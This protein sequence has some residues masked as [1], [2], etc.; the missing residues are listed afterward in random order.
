[1]SLDIWKKIIQKDY[2]EKIKEDVEY[3]TFRDIKP[4]C[5]ITGFNAGQLKDL[6]C[7]FFQEYTRDRDGVAYSSSKLKD[8]IEEGINHR[9]RVIISNRF[10]ALKFP[11]EE[12]EGY[13]AIFQEIAVGLQVNKLRNACPNFVY[14]FGLCKTDPPNSIRKNY[15]KQSY[16]CAVVEHINGEN[17]SKMVGKKSFEDHYDIY[18]QVWLSLA[19]AQSQIGLT[20]YDLHT[21]NIIVITLSETIKIDYPWGSIHTDKLVKI[22]DW[23]RSFSYGEY[24]N[25]RYT[26]GKLYPR[27]GIQIGPNYFYDCYLILKRSINRRKD[28]GMNDF[29]NFF[30]VE[31]SS[32]HEDIIEISKKPYDWFTW[33]RLITTHP[34]AKRCFTARG[35]DLP[36]P[37]HFPRIELSEEYTFKE[38]ERYLSDWRSGDYIIARKQRETE[39]RRLNVLR[40][41]RKLLTNNSP[42]PIKLEKVNLNDY[43]Q[44]TQEK[45]ISS[46]NNIISENPSKELIEHFDYYI[47]TILKRLDFLNRLI[48]FQS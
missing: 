34:Y 26:I 42:L 29:F 8:F 11:D 17:F 45:I 47:E 15:R 1:M 25:K 21:G 38:L 6:A 13:D 20:H 48:S 33:H 35:E 23:G 9:N 24:K 7:L 4:Y 40:S 36:N 28:D 5:K 18:L 37:L 43:T 32:N 41:G 16:H 30:E 22:I 27:L 10:F 3:R 19:F 46:L 39:Q 14:T 2:N 12:D 31:M 44:D